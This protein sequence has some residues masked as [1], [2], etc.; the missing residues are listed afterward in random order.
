LADQVQ[1]TGLGL[2]LVKKIVEAH[3]GTLRIQSRSPHGAE[4][5]VRIPVAPTEMQDEFAHIAG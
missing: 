3:S 5:I 1:G 4:G 2:N